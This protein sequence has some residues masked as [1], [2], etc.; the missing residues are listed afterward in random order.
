M[1]LSIQ[2]MSIGYGKKTIISD[3]KLPAIQPGSLVAVLGANAIGKSTLLKSMAGLLKFEGDATFDGQPLMSMSP[4]QRMNDIGYLPQ[5]LPQATSLVAYELVYCAC[6]ASRSG[7]NADARNARIEQVFK[8]LGIHNLA[9]KKMNEMSG[10]QR[11]MVGLAQVLVRQPKLLLLDEPTSA[12]DLHW[13]L[14]VLE[15]IREE[16]AQ[17]KAIA[18]VASHDLNLALRFCDQLLILT[19]GKVLAMGKPQEALTPKT[20]RDA[21]GIEGRIESCTQGYPIVL[22]DNA[23]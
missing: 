19:K 1:S 13:Q 16:T 17:H 21:Y 23:C 5:T 3:I 12:L 6:R 9:L 2:R 22:A 10:G 8:R 20:L 14:N 7:L 18:F 11:Q 15:A 4:H